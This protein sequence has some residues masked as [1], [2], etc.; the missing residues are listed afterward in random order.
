MNKIKELKEL[1]KK[2]KLKVINHILKE[3]TY[4]DVEYYICL[5]IVSTVSYL[6]FRILDEVSK[7]YDKGDIAIQLIPEMLQIKPKHIHN[8]NISWFGHH[9]SSDSKGIRTKKLL[10]LKEIIEKS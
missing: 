1:S 4:Y 3:W 8:N 7:K 9:Y 5:E 2:R 6:K 10:K